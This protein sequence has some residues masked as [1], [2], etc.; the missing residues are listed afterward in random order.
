MERTKEELSE[1]INAAYMAAKEEG[2]VTAESLLQEIE[3]LLNE[4]FI[5]EVVREGNALKENYS[6]GKSSIS[7]RKKSIN[8]KSGAEVFSAPLMMFTRRFIFLFRSPG[9]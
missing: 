6:T 9:S 5:G 4:Y 3:P 1:K 8:Q 2:S 7:L